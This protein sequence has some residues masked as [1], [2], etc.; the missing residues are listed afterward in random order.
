MADM[1]HVRG[2]GVYRVPKP[3]RMAAK[4][5]RNTCLN[6]A[7]ALGAVAKHTFRPLFGLVWA[8]ERPNCQ[9]SRGTRKLDA[10]ENRAIQCEGGPPTCFSWVP[11]GVPNQKTRIFTF[12]GILASAACYLLACCCPPSAPTTETSVA[13]VSSVTR[14]VTWWELMS[15]SQEPVYGCKAKGGEA[16][17]P[18]RSPRSA[19]GDGG[20][21][22]EPCP[23][24]PSWIRVRVTKLKFVRSTLAGLSNY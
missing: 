7:D 19:H 14:T 5:A 24:I 12:V 10:S 2:L 20:A 8:P 3:P 21:A 17:H 15:G 6:V 9:G 18:S 16:H 4:G 11:W 22:R 1:A 13:C 23:P